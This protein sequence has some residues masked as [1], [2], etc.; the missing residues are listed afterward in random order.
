MTPPAGGLTPRAGEGVPF[1]TRR[2]FVGSGST[3]YAPF[4]F[5]YPDSTYGQSR[6]DVRIPPATGLL[7]LAVTP[8]SAQVFVDSYYAGTVDDVNAQRVLELEAG[9]HR[10]ELRAAQY[11]TLTVDIRI[12][13]LETMTYRGALEPTRA[14]AAAAPA[15]TAPVPAC[16]P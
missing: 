1:H 10:L 2:P 12:T 16:P 5:G 9:P 6:P 11:Q 4:I 7:R 8:S 15:A 14:P 13:A 3:A